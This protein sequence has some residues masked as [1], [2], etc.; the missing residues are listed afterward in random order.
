MQCLSGARNR[1]HRFIFLWIAQAEGKSQQ[2]PATPLDYEPSFCYA[3]GWLRSKKFR[4][5]DSGLQDGMGRRQ[6]VHLVGGCR[7][8][9]E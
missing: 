8:V 4:A 7:Q 1:S 9:S 5:V 2:F 6:S 3:A